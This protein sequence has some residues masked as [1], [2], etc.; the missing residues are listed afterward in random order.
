MEENNQNMLLWQLAFLVIKGRF[1]CQLRRVVH[2]CLGNTIDGGTQP[3][4]TTTILKNARN[5][6]FFGE[7]NMKDIMELTNF[8]KENKKSWLILAK[9]SKHM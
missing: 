2:L 4:T 8:L 3:E 1:S 6:S 5:Q 7:R 9:M